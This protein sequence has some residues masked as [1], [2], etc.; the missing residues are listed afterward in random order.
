MLTTTIVYLLTT[1]SVQSQVVRWFK[2]TIEYLYNFV[3][4]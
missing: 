2:T 3:L 4:Y 1:P